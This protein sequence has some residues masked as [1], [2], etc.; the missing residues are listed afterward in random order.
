MKLSQN[1]A[2]RLTVILLMALDTYR[3][4]I[5][6]FY[7]IFVPQLCADKPGDVY[8]NATQISYHACSLEDNV[9]D[10]SDFNK[11]V[12][13]FNAFTGFMMLVAFIIEFKRENWIINHLDVDHSK[14]DSNLKTEI[15]TYTKMKK[16]ITYKNW[17][18][19]VI[20]TSVGVISII[21]CT[22]SAV[23]MVYYFDGLKTVTTFIT[24]SL[25][26]GM[27]VG[28][29][30]SIARSNNLETK[31]QSVTLTEPVTFNTI[32]PKYRINPESKPTSFSDAN[33]M[34]KPKTE[35]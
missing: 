6:S 31:A 14:P 34:V 10:L 1:N 28:K 32:D 12:L 33:P 9:T 3:I 35:V 24:N 30:I 13:A 25:L 19:M 29:S 22:A 11:F 17:R 18:Y 4:V 27:R 26:I 23:L 21:N 16:S 20:F 2:Q 8:Y 5:G 15:E 7:S